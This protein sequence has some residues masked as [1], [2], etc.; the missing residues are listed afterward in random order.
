MSEEKVTIVRNDRGLDFRRIEEII[1]R[2]R[3]KCNKKASQLSEIADQ[4]QKE[5]KETA[6][7]HFGLTGYISQIDDIDNQIKI[8]Y[9]LKLTYTKKVEEFTKNE[10][11]YGT[12]DDIRKGSKI[13]NYISEGVAEIDEQKK[14]ISE[15]AEKFEDEVW[16][17]KDIEHATEL[18]KTFLY[19]LEKS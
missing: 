10:E 17:A 11:K 1:K 2:F 8:L 16:F 4:K 12:Y 9:E 7:E 14:Q 18:F 6:F 15:I 3:Q 19:Q 5:L 13:A